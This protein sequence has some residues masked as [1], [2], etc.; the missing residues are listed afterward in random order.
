MSPFQT[1]S[2]LCPAPADSAPLRVGWPDR[3]RPQHHQI[4][5]RLAWL[6]LTWLER[7]FGALRSIAFRDTVKQMHGYSADAVLKVA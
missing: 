2:R 7:A 4:A 5:Q 6:G 3:L 1:L